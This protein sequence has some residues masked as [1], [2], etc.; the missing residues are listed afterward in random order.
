MNLAE[1]LDTWGFDRARLGFTLRTAIA[2]CCAVVLAWLAGFEHPQWSGMTVWAASQPMRGQLLEK[3]VFRV[4]GT[5]LGALFGTGLL[6]AAQGQAWVLVLGLSVWIGLCAWAGNVMRGFASYGAMLAGY[7]AAMVALLHSQQADNPFAV[8]L[9]RLLTVLLGVLVALALGWFFARKSNYRHLA[10]QARQQGREVL[11]LLCRALVPGKG[12]DFRRSQQLLADMAAAEEALDGLGAGSL[13]ARAA[14]RA[15]RRQLAAQ[16]SLLLWMRRLP[17]TSETAAFGQA[18]QDAAA[19]LASGGSARQAGVALARAAG[20]A[21]SRALQEA[22]ESLAQ[23]CRRYDQVETDTVARRGV[24]AMQLATRWPGRVRQRAAV[25]QAG[26]R[27]NEVALH[28]DWRGGR[29][30]GARAALAILFAGAV[31]QWTEWEA[32]PFMLLGVAIM[33]T[34]FSTADN[35]VRL[36]RM[37]VLGQSLGILG[38]LACRWLVWPQMDSAAGLVF[39]M[40]PF[41]LLGGLFM[42][43]RRGAGPLGFDFSMVFLLLLQPDWPL[44]V[45]DAASL[46]HSLQTALAVVLG[47]LL[48]LLAFALVF[49]VDSAR[50]MRALSAAMMQELQKMAARRGVSRR[51]SG[52]RIRLS[53]RVLALVR[54]ADKSGRSRDEVIQ[55]G[56]AAMLLGA[57]IL[58]M[59]EVLLTPGQTPV[60]ARRLAATLIRLQR[61]EDAPVR[62][63]QALHRCVASLAGAP[64]VDVR[65]LGDA[66]QA[67]EQSLARRPAGR[68]PRRPK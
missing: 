32:G 15:L 12:A 48:G 21:H 65:L 22:L 26:M 17:Q 47:P 34:I 18:L 52:W 64:G 36:L 33:T 62:A 49:P 38:A 19:V 59:D 54:W 40:L 43:H 60:A 37:V 9:D 27:Q 55:E 44:P 58:H 23:A 51:R 24:A 46:L 66:A 6:A 25:R 53:H 45:S 63:A 4:Q 57:S 39:S 7:S 42:G 50:R 20:L 5:I 2:A 13:K 61:L 10:Q 68:G 29:E 16:V 1:R 67:L 11:E 3:S 35:P 56:Y 41:V 14:V 31:W 30:A 28:R 8:G